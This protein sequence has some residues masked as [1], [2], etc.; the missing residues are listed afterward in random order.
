MFVIELCLIS[1]LWGEEGEGREEEGT[2]VTVS[3]SFLVRRVSL[4]SPPPPPF[5]RLPQINA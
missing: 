5:W 1:V 3:P 2:E 4:F